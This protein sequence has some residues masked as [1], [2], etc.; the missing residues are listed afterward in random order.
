MDI[1]AMLKRQQYRLIGS[2]SAIKICHWTKQALRGKG[3]CY[4]EQFYGIACHR[5]LQISPAIFWC[6]NRCLK[7]WRAIEIT[8]AN[9][10]DTK[11]DEPE[12]I[13][14]NAIIA[15]RQ[16]LSG[17][18]GLK[19]VDMAKWAE[20]QR[21]NQAA[22]SLI[23]EPTAY[24]KISELIGVF[25]RRGFTTF[26]VSNGQFPERLKDMEEP[27]QLYISLD[28]PNKILLKKLNQPQLPDFW[29]RLNKS[30]EM[31]SSFGCRKVI[32]LT[33]IRGFNI[34]K[35]EGYAKLIEKAEPD[36]VEI[37]G[38]MHVG[39]SQQ[40]LPKSAMP[41]HE[42]IRNFAKGLAEKIGYRIADEQRV[43]RVV[44]LSKN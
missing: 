4:K 14:A 43:S 16:L 31:M 12:E 24:P 30:L 36:F 33:I 22:I 27:T 5:C 19:G 2:H 13:V 8:K 6:P 42:E 15:Q 21:P 34:S 20:A 37:K 25:K 3:V 23:G 11:L 18:K 26:L 35:P 40:R 32:R 41:E 7:C 44:L 10:I 9:Q 38:Y 29:E 1:K 28:A 17:F 39:F